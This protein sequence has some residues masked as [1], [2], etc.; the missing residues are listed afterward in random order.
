MQ[1]GQFS[2][3]RGRG[4][5]NNQARKTF[6]SYVND[7]GHRLDIEGTDIEGTDEITTTSLALL[8]RDFVDSQSVRQRRF[9]LSHARDSKDQTRQD[10]WLYC[11]ALLDLETLRRVVPYGGRIVESED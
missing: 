3:N 11:A 4:T 10:G 9:I 6:T 1:R 5:Q 2:R 7:T 8:V